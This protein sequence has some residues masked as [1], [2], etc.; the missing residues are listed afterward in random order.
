MNTRN[1]RIGSNL[2]DFL[3]EQE[4]KEEV[5]A[6]ALKRVHAWQIGASNDFGGTHENQPQ[7]SG[8]TTPAE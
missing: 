7:N 5:S 2:D 4:L 6:A 8:P 3:K 1:P